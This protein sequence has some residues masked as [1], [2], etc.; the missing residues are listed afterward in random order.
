MSRSGLRHIACL[1]GLVVAG[2]MISGPEVKAEGLT[3]DLFRARVVDV[4]LYDQWARKDKKDGLAKKCKCAAKSY[5]NGLDKDAL[6]KALDSGK[7]SY[8]GKRSLLKKLEKC[9]G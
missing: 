6:A 3:K 8:E 9:R 1:F 4:C 2:F 7:L 5:V